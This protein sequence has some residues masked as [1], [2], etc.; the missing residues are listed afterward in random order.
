M[1]LLK[2]MQLALDRE[3]RRVIGY[4]RQLPALCF[5]EAGRAL[6]PIERKEAAVVFEPLAALGADEPCAECGE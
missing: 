5:P 1:A 3:R 4:R 2:Q 6:D